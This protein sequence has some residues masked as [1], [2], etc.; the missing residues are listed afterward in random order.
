M[1]RGSYFRKFLKLCFIM[2]VLLSP[3]ILAQ[4]TGSLKGKV[5]D[6]ATNEALG[7][8][9]IIIQGT[10]LGAAADLDGNF[11]IRNIPAGNHKIIVSY[12][13]Y[14]SD[15]TEINLVANRTI[16]QEFYLSL[17][18]VEGQTVVVTSQA[19]G[20]MSAIQSAINI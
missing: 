19:Q 11:V 9:N 20:Q 2:S 17:N 15:S 18:V 12:I 14:N 5:L 7:G 4:G 16:E 1:F 6:K 13:G 3:A 10:T 8:A